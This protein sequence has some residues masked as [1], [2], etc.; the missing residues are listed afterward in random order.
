MC[1]I[2]VY[3]VPNR[4]QGHKYKSQ[5]TCF[6]TPQNEEWRYPGAKKQS[7][8]VSNSSAQSYS[9]YRWAFFFFFHYNS[10][11]KKVLKLEKCSGFQIPFSSLKSMEVQ[12][13]LKKNK[14]KLL[15]LF[16]CET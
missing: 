7:S 1:V 3:S 6:P 15:L 4:A 13:T 9:R 16:E 10:H 11:Y 8:S 2:T 5:V 12:K 14:T